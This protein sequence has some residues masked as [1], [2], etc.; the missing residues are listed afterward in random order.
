MVGAFNHITTV[1][2]GSPPASYSR[3]QRTKTHPA[4][5]DIRLSGAALRQQNIFQQRCTIPPFTN[6]IQIEN[7]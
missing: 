7:V 3:R 4:A 5:G 1:S 6:T 2:C